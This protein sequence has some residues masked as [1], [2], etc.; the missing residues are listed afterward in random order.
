MLHYFGEIYDETKC[1]GLCDNCRFPKETYDATKNVTLALGAV[2]KLDQKFGITHLVQ[3]LR[4]SENQAV[5]LYEHDKLPI[6]GKGAN[7]SEKEWKNVFS[8][9]IV[10]NYLKKDI[11][12]YGTLKLTIKGKRFLDMPSKIRLFSSISSRWS[13]ATTSSPV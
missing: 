1:T 7:Y 11:E 9:I 5:Q 6:H 8:Q 4:G 3:V 13:W 2:E 12:E 10:Q